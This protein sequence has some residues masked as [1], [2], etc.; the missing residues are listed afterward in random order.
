[1]PCGKKIK[2]KDFVSHL[3]SL[4]LDEGIRIEGSRRKGKIFVNKN[5]SGAYVLQQ[6]GIDGNR[7]LTKKNNNHHRLRHDDDIVYLDSAKQVFELVK[8]T[9]GKNFS[10]WLY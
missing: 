10:V 3:K 9:F 7:D 1:L 2:I 8:T 4:D 6:V 5:P